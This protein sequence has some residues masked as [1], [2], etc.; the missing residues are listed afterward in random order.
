MVWVET[1][2][3]P[4]ADRASTSR[5]SPRSRTRAALSS[6]S[7]T[8]SPRRTCSSRSRSAPTSSCTRPRSTSAATA[9]SSAASSPSTTPTLAER[10]RFM[11]NAA[12]AVPAPFDC[13]LVLRG[14]KTLAR[15]DG[16]ALRERRA[17]S[18]T[19]CSATQQSTQVLLPGAARPSRPRRRR[20]SRCATSAAWCRSSLRGRRGGGADGRAA[21]PSCSRSPSRSARSRA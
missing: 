16:S 6:S 10:L 2:D 8:P 3:Q 17:P 15:A 14:V 20:P 12:G 7:T 11:Q 5:R 9:T 21:A 18:S 1:P 13:Y 4:A 19:C